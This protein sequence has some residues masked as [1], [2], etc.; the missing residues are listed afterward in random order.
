MSALSPRQMFLLDEACKPIAEG[1]GTPWLVGTSGVRGPYRDVDVRV[2]LAD[3]K[4]KKLQKAIGDEGIYLMGLT[5]GQYLAERTD[6]PIDFQIQ[7]MS[8]ANAQHPGGMRNPLGR[9]TLHS[10]RGDTTPIKEKN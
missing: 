9:R 1:L 7:Q 10:Y 6:L 4:Y 3:K 2:M 5:M 8:A